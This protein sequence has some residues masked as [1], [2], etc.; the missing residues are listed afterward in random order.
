MDIYHIGLGILVFIFL[1][2]WLKCKKNCKPCEPCKP[3]DEE[4]EE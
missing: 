3:C 2:A 1:V 4:K